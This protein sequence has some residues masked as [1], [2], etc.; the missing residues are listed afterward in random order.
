MFDIVNHAGPIKEYKAGVL[1]IF[2]KKRKILI[3]FFYTK[4]KKEFPSLSLFS[5][6]FSVPLKRYI[7]FVGVRDL[8]RQEQQRF[9]L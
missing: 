5:F 8:L 9:R 1:Y 4:K 7:V 2:K 6:F 3:L